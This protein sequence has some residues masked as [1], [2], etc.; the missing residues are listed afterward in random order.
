VRIPS[1]AAQPIAGRPAALG[2]KFIGWIPSKKNKLRPRSAP[3]TGRGRSGLVYDKD[4]K[5]ALRS[6]ETQARV[7]W[8]PRK[9]WLHPLLEVR[10]LVSN[11]DQDLDGM[12]TALLDAMKKARVIVDDSISVFNGGFQVRPAEIVAT[13]RR[14][15][16]VIL[17]P[18]RTVG[19]PSFRCLGCGASV[20]DMKFLLARTTSPTCGSIGCIGQWV[21][22]D[23]N[24][25]RGS[26]FYA[27]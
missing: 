9:P 25:F 16:D 22:E 18:N 20:D 12:F 1:L 2:L 14:G 19:S 7:Q 21:P 13:E 26:E 5:Q 23:S 17:T 8:G 27:G 6:L 24:L 3:A 11:E 10:F 4:V 15:A